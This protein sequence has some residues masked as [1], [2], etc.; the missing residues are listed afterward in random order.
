MVLICNLAKWDNLQCLQ[1]TEVYLQVRLVTFYY[2]YRVT[3]RPQTRAWWCM[4]LVVLQKHSAANGSAL[5]ANRGVGEDSLGLNFNWSAFE[6]VRMNSGWSMFD[7]CSEVLC[8]Q[9]NLYVWQ[10]WLFIDLCSVCNIYSH[11]CYYNLNCLGSW[12]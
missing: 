5:Q 10:I 2:L 7:I 3:H 6:H 11:I 4:M 1:T 8:W 12:A 9:I